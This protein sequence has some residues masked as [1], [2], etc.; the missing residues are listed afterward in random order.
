MVLSSLGFQLAF[1]RRLLVE[2]LFLAF[3][4]VVIDAVCVMATVVGFLKTCFK[5]S[6]RPVAVAAKQKTEAAPLVMM[7]TISW[8]TRCP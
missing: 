7:V 5:A 2:R 8:T 4:L 3:Q 1:D 6:T